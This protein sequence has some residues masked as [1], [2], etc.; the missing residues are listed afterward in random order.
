METLYMLRKA[1]RDQVMSQTTVYEWFKRFK[2]GRESPRNMRLQKSKVKTMLITFF[3][4]EGLIHEKF[5]PEGSTVNGKY[6]S[7]VMQYLLATIRR[8]QPQY[9][10]QGSWSLLHDNAPAHKCIAMRNFRAS[11]SVQVFD[12]PAYSPD[13]SSCDYFLFPKLK[14]QLKRLRFDIISE[15]QKVST[16]ALTTITKKEYKRCF[17]KLYDRSKDCI[18]SK[19]MYFE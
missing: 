7:G 3:D 2:E 18:S 13:L 17:Q 4:S 19:G 9:K 1:Y 5:V 15:I 16:E 12:H 10:A 6:Y 11:K 8:V 14:M